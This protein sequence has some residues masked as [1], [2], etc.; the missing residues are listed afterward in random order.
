M[1]VGAAKQVWSILR[2]AGPFPSLFQARLGPWK[3]V[4]TVCSHTDTSSED[5]WIEV[6]PSQKKFRLHEQDMHDTTYQHPE[7]LTFEVLQWSHMPVESCLHIDYLPLLE[8]RGVPRE[9]LE[10]LVK[11]MLDEHREELENALDSPP[12]LY[13]WIEDNFGHDAEVTDF[14]DVS[15]SKTPA[16][17]IKSLIAVSNHLLLLERILTRM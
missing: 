6:S 14:A 17:R 1:S 9:A 13:K 10:V 3:G 11:H 12:A 15:E 7:R 5:I 2:E 8:D 4:W 16:D